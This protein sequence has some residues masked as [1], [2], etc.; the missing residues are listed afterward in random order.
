MTGARQPRAL[1]TRDKILATLERL[2]EECEFEVITIAHLA[3]EAGIA[4]GSVYS[5]F[6]D[7]DALLPALLDRHLARTRARIQEVTEAGTVDEL[8]LVLGEGENLR[9]GIERS[10]RGVLH[11]IDAS[12]GIRRALLTYRRLHPDAEMPL[13]QLLIDETLNAL[14]VDLQRY[15]EDIVHDDL[16]QAAQMVIYFINVAFLDRIV[17]V[18]SALQER[19]RPPDDALVRIYTGMIYSY[20][21]GIA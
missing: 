11:Q 14:I 10:I 6:A 8:A 19:M 12:R 7:R 17:F 16:D 2:L 1:A 9:D 3:R 5:H 15:R 13:A 4:V 21:T 18:R 20:L